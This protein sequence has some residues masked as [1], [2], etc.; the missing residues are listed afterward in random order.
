MLRNPLSGLSLAC[1]WLNAG[2]GLLLTATQFYNGVRD[3]LG[4]KN[5]LLRSREGM[6]ISM[7]NVRATAIADASPGTEDEKLLCS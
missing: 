4:Y 3:F 5:L 7:S 1:A 6:H 2:F